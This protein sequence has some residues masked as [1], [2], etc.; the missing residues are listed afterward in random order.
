VFV[1]YGGSATSEFVEKIVLFQYF[2]F[3]LLYSFSFSS[4]S[5][6]VCDSSGSSCLYLSKSSFSTW[7][8]LQL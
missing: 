1:H 7:S 5:I 2:R 8:R 6:L 4:S 3:L